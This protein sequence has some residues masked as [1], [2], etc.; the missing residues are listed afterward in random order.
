MLCYPEDRV[1]CPVIFLNECGLQSRTLRR[2]PD[3][4][5][6]RFTP[7]RRL[8]RCSQ[9]TH[10]YCGRQIHIFSQCKSN[11]E[12]T[13]GFPGIKRGVGVFPKLGLTGL[14]VKGIM[15][16]VPGWRADR[17]LTALVCVQPFHQEFQSL[18]RRDFR[19]EETLNH[20]SVRRHAIYNSCC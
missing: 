5:F 19:E 2:I 6:N 11:C 9:S 15:T 13:R 18:F 17:D 16:R 14:H 7:L 1:H 20:Q 10:S 8:Q 4:C 3:H 12:A